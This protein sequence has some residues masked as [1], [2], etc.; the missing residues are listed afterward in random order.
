MPGV[1]RSALDW[2]LLDN[3]RR[4]RIETIDALNA[5]LARQLPVSSR[6]GAAPVISDDPEPNLSDESVHHDMSLEHFH[7]TPCN[8]GDPKPE[9]TRR[10]VQKRREALREAR[11]RQQA[12]KEQIDAACVR[13]QA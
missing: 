2:A 3:P 5:W 11:E 8:L 9:E 12:R 4:L 10:L 1:G 6:L 7:E 13:L